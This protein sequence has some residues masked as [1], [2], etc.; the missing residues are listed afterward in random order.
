[1]SSPLSAP[2]PDLRIVQVAN[3]HP[4]EEHD[5]QRALPLIEQLQRA[6][7]VTNPPIVA[8]MGSDEYVI[9]DGANRCYVFNHLGYEH[10]LVQ[11]IAY[12]SGYVELD[13][14]HHVI[15][16]WDAD[17]LLTQLHDLPE[18]RL[19]EGQNAHA[20][21]HL[22]M[23]DGTIFGL[24]APVNNTHERNA[25]LRNV[26]R[27]YQRSAKL[28]RTAIVEPEDNWELYPDGIALMVFPTYHAADIIAAA[29]H[30][31]YL[32][33]GISRHIVHGRALSVNYPLDQL[34]DMTVSLDEKNAALKSWMQQ[35]LAN[36][37]VRYYAEAT[38]QFNEY[39]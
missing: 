37:Q 30:K 19:T 31:A 36:R 23:R 16:S 8:P 11:V 12:E 29:K 18:I 15:G 9:L 5:S 33:P 34:R 2:P 13:N 39:E 38:Y 25:A 27:V 28:H 35:K 7:Y 26:V 17:E 10:V 1:M 21:A 32:P 14:W 4:H 20:I 6:S 22:F 3:V 24:Q